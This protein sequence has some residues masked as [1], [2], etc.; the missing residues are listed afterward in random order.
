[1]KK[2]TTLFSAM[3]AALV[4]VPV[5]AFETGVNAM[6]IVEDLESQPQSLTAW[7]FAEL[8]SL[9][10]GFR[11][12]LEPVIPRRQV[13]FDILDAEI[14]QFISEGHRE[15]SRIESLIE[16]IRQREEEPAAQSQT[17]VKEPELQAN[18]FRVISDTPDFG[19]APSI[20][21]LNDEGTLVDIDT[22]NGLD[23][24]DLTI[25]PRNGGD[26]YSEIESV[27][28]VLDIVQLVQDQVPAPIQSVGNELY[29]KIT[30][31]EG[32]A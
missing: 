26:Y 9:E 25:D 4:P 8:R 7:A 13:E 29:N 12:L 1:M 5:F 3:M 2:R 31:S 14:T 15:V 18:E 24:P 17:V 30:G 10:V 19:M 21:V 16:E 22:S 32:Q 6:S 20:Q 11:Q 23:L 28:Q 27:Q